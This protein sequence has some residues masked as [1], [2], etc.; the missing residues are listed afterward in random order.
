MILIH[1]I[2]HKPQPVISIMG[3]LEGVQTSP[4]RINFC[5]PEGKGRK[6]VS[7]KS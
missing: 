6:I 7:N 3:Y 2:K 4:H 5:H 1:F